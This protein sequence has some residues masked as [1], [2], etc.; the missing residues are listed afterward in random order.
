MSWLFVA[1]IV[2]FTVFCVAYMLANSEEFDD[3]EERVSQTLND[4]DDL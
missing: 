2:L 3:I 1:I 4:E